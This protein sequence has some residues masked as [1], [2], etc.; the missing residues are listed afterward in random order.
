MTRRGRGSAG[1]AIGICEHL[2]NKMGLGEIRTSPEVQEG[3]ANPRIP[4]GLQGRG[5]VPIVNNGLI[6]TRN[7]PG[8]T[9]NGVCCLE[10]QYAT[11][12]APTWAFTRL[13]AG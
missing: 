11:R 5:C 1:A 4:T 2:E 6:S 8:L 9:P 3:N 7:P 13:R 10:G 12:L